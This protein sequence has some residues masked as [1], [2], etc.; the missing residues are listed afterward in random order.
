M[1]WWKYKP[2]FDI[3]WREP[4]GFTLALNKLSEKTTRWSTRPFW[5]IVITGIFLGLWAIT[6]PNPGVR[7]IPMASALPFCIAAGFGIVYF[8]SI[9]HR[10]ATRTIGFGPKTIVSILGQQTA[11]WPYEL[12]QEVKFEN[13]TFGQK[14]FRIMVVTMKD[15]PQLV[16]AVPEKIKIQE[17]IDYLKGKGI[18]AAQTA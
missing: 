13:Q 14:Q 3:Q 7:R 16:A 5:S 10:F 1:S 9:V 8:I 18:E 15:R 2:M 12:V 6:Q 4:Y 17:V 11:P